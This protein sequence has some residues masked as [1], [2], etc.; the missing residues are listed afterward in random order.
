[1]RLGAFIPPKQQD[2][3]KGWEVLRELFA[4]SQGLEVF[5]KTDK[6]PQGDRLPGNHASQTQRT[7]PLLDGLG[8]SAGDSTS[9]NNP[10]LR[11][12]R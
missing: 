2:H 11:G 6:Y 3:A 4:P 7:A 8:G 12:A 9:H 10:V 1:M 5:I